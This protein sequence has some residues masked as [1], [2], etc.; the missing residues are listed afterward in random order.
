MDV[1]ELA[2]YLSP[3][4]GNPFSPVQGSDKYD[5][6]WDIFPSPTIISHTRQVLSAVRFA[7]TFCNDSLPSVGSEVGQQ[8][9]VHAR[10]LSS[11]EVLPP[12]PQ[13]D[14]GLHAC[15]LPLPTGSEP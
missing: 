7:P 3:Q 13:P 2:P 5:R 14:P 6:T 9:G 11:P 10:D 4:P 15:P 8:A 1:L 12:G